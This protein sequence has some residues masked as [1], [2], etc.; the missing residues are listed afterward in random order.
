MI[1]QGS[2][3]NAPRRSATSSSLQQEQIFGTDPENVIDKG[4]FVKLLTSTAVE[5]K[6]KHSWLSLSTTRV[7]A[8]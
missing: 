1:S 6:S 5:G 2:F 7:S 3:I 4:S 8:D